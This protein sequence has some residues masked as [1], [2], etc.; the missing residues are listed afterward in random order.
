M[1]QYCVGADHFA[2]SGDKPD[3]FLVVIHEG[4]GATGDVEIN[5]GGVTREHPVEAIAVHSRLI[6]RAATMSLRR[7]D[8][9]KTWSGGDDEDV[10][11]EMGVVGDDAKGVAMWLNELRV[12]DVDQTRAMSEETDSGAFVLSFIQV[13]EV[14]EGNGVDLLVDILVVGHA[15]LFADFL[16]E[17]TEGDVVL[18]ESGVVVGFHCSGDDVEVMVR[19]GTWES[20]ADAV[21]N[22]EVAEAV[23]SDE[24]IHWKSDEAIENAREMSVGERRGETLC[25]TYT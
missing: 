15:V 20:V 3:V 19:I 6:C 18:T 23:F 9:V 1:F 12:G 17:E 21:E 5:G 25:L 13:F 4:E 2:R 10:V 7:E 24:G 22:E 11:E 14:A 8:D 16:E